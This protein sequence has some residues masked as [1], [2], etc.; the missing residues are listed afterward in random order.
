[1]KK[2]SKK[3]VAALAKVDRTKFYSIEESIKLVKDACF[4]KFDETIDLSF[5]LG[6]DPRHA[7]QMV[8]GALSLPAGTGKT[9]RIA[10][11]TAGEKLKEFLSK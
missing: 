9:V 3:Y 10:V 6:I 1:M 5:R 2:R 4:A 11:I 8:R 7:D